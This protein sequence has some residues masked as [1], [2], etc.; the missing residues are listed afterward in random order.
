M[1]AGE[2]RARLRTIVLAALPRHEGRRTTWDVEAMSVFEETVRPDV[3]LALLDALEAAEREVFEE[4]VT[5]R[6]A[7][8]S[9]VEQLRRSS[10][11][12]AALVAERDRLIARVRDLETRLRK[13]H[14][15][16]DDTSADEAVAL[17]AISVECEEALGIGRAA[18][19]T[20]DGSKSDG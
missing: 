10:A 13:I 12:I 20:A 8:Q 9:E 2:Q 19:A 5:E 14:E 15:Y 11:P 3:V 6:D 17:V 4:A 16:A 18:L 1:I 7:L